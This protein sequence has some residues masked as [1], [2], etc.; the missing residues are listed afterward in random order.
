MLGIIRHFWKMR[1]SGHLRAVSAALAVDTL[2]RADRAAATMRL[3]QRFAPLNLATA[4]AMA[5]VYAFRV[6]QSMIL[7][8]ALPII[9]VVAVFL[10][11]TWR[12]KLQQRLA[13]PHNGALFVSCYALAT[14]VAWII[15]IGVLN[16]TPLSEDRIG[17]F[18]VTVAVICLGGMI[19]T[20]LPEAA[21]IFM[22]IVSIRLAIDLASVVAFPAFYVAAIG[23]FVGSLEMLVIG[24]AR[25][26]ADRNRAGIEL[27]ALERR[28]IDEER[29][30]AEDQRALEREHERR[31]IAEQQRAADEQHEAMGGHAQRFET[32]V[33]AVIDKLSGAARELGGAIANLTDM[34][35]ASGNHVAAVRGRALTVAQS[36]A[37]VQQAA[38]D[39]RAAIGAIS[40]EVAA[41]V[42]ATANAETVAALA[43]SQA[44][45]LADSSAMVRGIT[46]KIERIAQHTNTLA[47]N[48]LIEATQSGEAGAGFAVVA[49]EVKAL[50]AQTR[51]AALEIGGHIAD[52][53]A[54]AGDVAASV[55][56][57]ANDVGR[58]AVGATD[59][60]RAIEAQ[61]AST[62]GILAGV[63]GARDGAQTVQT[64]LEAL[65]EQACAA[66]GLA[67]LIERVATDIG[68]QS[69]R[70]GSASVDFG[71][72]LRRA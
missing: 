5:M 69:D 60:A 1:S 30:A 53:D 26:F 19:F 39:L 6:K 2:S 59:I 27:A 52:M 33:V 8:G 48:A 45:E 31:R 23:V 38:G 21:L 50:A 42:N 3:A 7:I 35:E 66:V 63:E 56:A 61:R 68:S 11:L 36:M 55:S 37:A 34:G 72:R 49:G 57:I 28:R 14:G 16:M 22:M 25:L 46:A 51:A 20:L 64:D 43:R 58:I 47:L 67:H 24:Q 54:N 40:R 18:C 9:M 13:G 10:M 4:L 17:L 62:D 12:D 65:A 41:Q 44:R 71:E 15:L 32:S 70:L 29:R